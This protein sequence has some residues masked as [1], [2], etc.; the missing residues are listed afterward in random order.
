MT[1]A[2]LS[3]DPLWPRTGSWPAPG[4]LP[5]EKRVDLAIIGVPTWRTSLSPTQAHTTPDA[6]RD[7]LRRYS[8][9]AA[10]GF[11]PAPHSGNS[12]VGSRGETRTT[13][14]PSRVTRGDL[15][16]E[17]ALTVVD[18]GNLEE[19]DA[20]WS[21]ADAITRI[22]KITRDVQLMLA[23]GGDNA[24]TVPAALGTWG[25]DITTAGLIT[26]D[27]HH[28]LRDGISNGSPVRRLI[29]AG[30][31]GTRVV[32]IGIAD[33]ANSLE[34]TRRAADLGITV[35]HRN[36]LSPASITDAVREALKIAGSA[37]GPVHV[38]IDVDVCDR[39]VA[40]ACPASLPGGLT[41][42]ELRIATRF[43]ARDPRVRSIDLTEI[44]ATADTPDAR[45]VRLAALLVL[46]SAAGLV[47]RMPITTPAR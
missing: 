5:P 31:S 3:H 35:I 36:D 32:Q 9:Y 18:C 20:G 12:S 8:G 15:V 7:A 39:S 34:Y 6:I 29:E 44:D 13:S 45:T 37:G 19:P 26:F 40:P 42:H 16:I 11:T 10:T 47:E 41:A 24:A 38:D 21:E 4:S 17:D 14:Q 28:D 23:L 46:E 2:Q 1:S 27:A 30:L 43:I 22:T 25:T 33:F